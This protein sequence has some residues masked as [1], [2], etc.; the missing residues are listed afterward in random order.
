MN[1]DFAKCACTHC[2][3][4]IEFPLSELETTVA[5]PQCGEQT[6]LQAEEP[7]SEPVNTTD[8]FQGLTGVLKKQRLSLFY[9]AGMLLV[10]LVMILLPV[11]YIMLIGG[12]VWGCIWYAQHAI[13]LLS[14]FHGGI[15]LYF[16]KLALYVGPL[17]AGAIA[18]LFMFK[19]IL[20]R[21]P[22]G[23]EPIAL[24]PAVEKTLYAFIAKICDM[25]EAPMPTRISLDCEL[26]A[27]A[28]F[29]KGMKSMFGN[30]LELRLGLPL[31][32]ALNTRELA[33]IIAH[34]FGHF[35]QGFGMRLNYVTR[36]INL[37]F[38]RVVYQN[39]TWDLWLVNMAHDSETWWG[40]II[41]TCALLAVWFSRFILKCLMWIGDATSCF[42]TRQMEY[43]ADSN[44]IQ[45]AGSATFESTLIR[46]A[47][48]NAAL[49]KSYSEI[50]V[51]WNTNRRLPD[52]F[53][54]Y[55][56]KVESA[57]PPEIRERIENIVGFQKTHLFSTHPSVA[58]R[59]RK[60]R[61]AQSP[62]LYQ[63]EIPARELFANFNV[64]CNLVTRLHYSDDIGIEYDPSMLKAVSK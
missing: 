24:N 11:L 9:Q 21:M 29:R 10:T 38:D 1:G 55:L 26:S 2:G 41:V 53:P 49:K 31:V 15:Y 46:L 39:D 50:Q 56:L 64:A 13:V 52:N 25:V 28:G 40:G 60:A 14:N 57:I 5:C 6:F 30:D 45:L 32:A 44:E 63:T 59:I 23:P 19:P 4:H 17:F 37:W 18:V 3:I 20:A 12:I 61:A 22:E 54:E 35:N 36:R 58:D 48:L 16:L 27:S 33:G 43:N 62:G 7:P 34:E 8:V 47:V 42:F 51:Q